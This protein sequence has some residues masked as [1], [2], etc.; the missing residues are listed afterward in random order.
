MYW[1]VMDALIMWILIKKKIII[2]L[3][4]NYYVSCV[5]DVARCRYFCVFKPFSYLPDNCEHVYVLL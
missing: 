4:A 3:L 1:L 2:F 5:F